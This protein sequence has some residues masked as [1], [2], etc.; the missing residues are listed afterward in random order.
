M[1]ENGETPPEAQATPEAAAPQVPKLQVLG[2][3]IR[4]CSFENIMVQKGVAGEITPEINVQ[5]SME[6]KKRPVDNQYEVVTKYTV[7]SRNQTGQETLFI[8]EIQYG[9]IFLIENVADE[10]LHP[11]LMIECPRMLFPFVRRLV[12]DLTREGGFP[13]F[14]ME[15]VDFVAL[16]RQMIQQKA[17]EA[18][19]QTLS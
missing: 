4:D 17:A 19:G 12:A 1:A 16:Y 6:A 8:L 11:F 15:T 2:Q 18:K 7:T 10:Q 13:P 9:G 5:V 14:N 3:F